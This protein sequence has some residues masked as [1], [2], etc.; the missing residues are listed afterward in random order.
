MILRLADL[1]Y[2]FGVIPIACVAT[3]TVPPSIPNRVAVK[4]DL[5]SN[6]D[7]GRDLSG[8]YTNGA[9]PMITVVDLT[10]SGVNLH[11]VRR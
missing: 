5:Y 9:Q 11:T 3:C 10:L 1:S 7:E 8:L 2:N 6:E 4:L